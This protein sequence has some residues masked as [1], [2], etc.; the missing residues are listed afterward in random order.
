[1]QEKVIYISPYEN[2]NE[3]I[4]IL[5][6][7][8]SDMGFLVQDMEEITA[9]KSNARRGE[10]A[11]INWLEDSPC[12]ENSFCKSFKTFVRTIKKAVL[13]KR[14]T[15]KV[16]WIRHNYRPHDRNLGQTFSRILTWLFTLL[17]FHVLVLESTFKGDLVLHP[18]YVTD[19]EAS[20]IIK[21]ISTS[22]SE[23]PD[24][25]LFFGAIKPYKNL[26]VALDTWPQ[27]LPLLIIGKCSDKSYFEKLLKIV[28]DRG[29]KV[30]LKN[31]FLSKDDLDT[32]LMEYSYIL[33]PHQD[34]TIISS[35]TFYHAIS[36]GCKIIA[37]HSTFS[38]HKASQHN[39][40]IIK[41][42]FT[43]LILDLD[44][45]KVTRSEVIYDAVNSYGKIKSIKYWESLFKNVN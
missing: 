1:M 27:E 7:I 20:E 15:K 3:F 25:V 45:N 33:M 2:Q 22:E 4:S 12:Y 40:L 8:F 42:D 26:H 28:D 16:F 29:L 31:T 38:M 21:K 24:K 32:L 34:Q 18:L 37:L 43:N 11:V 14:R 44:S 39:F 36:F 30:T 5:K 9:I 19:E 35:G 13:L 6:N 23:K 17:D 41:E 10:L